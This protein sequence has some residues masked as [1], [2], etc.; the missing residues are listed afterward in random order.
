VNRPH[1]REGHPQKVKSRLGVFEV[2]E[3]ADG[4]LQPPK[5]LLANEIAHE[6]IAAKGNAQHLNLRVGH[7]LDLTFV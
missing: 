2:D 4:G 6:G 5:Q 1:D 3:L 7:K